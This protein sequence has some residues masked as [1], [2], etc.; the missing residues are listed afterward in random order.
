MKVPDIYISGFFTDD[1][2]NEISAI[3]AEINKRGITLG[4]RNLTG[5]MFH[6]ALDFA[7]LEILALSYEFAVAIIHS[8]CYDFLKSLILKLWNISQK[9]NLEKIP[10]TIEIDG[11]PYY[12]SSE[13]IKCKVYGK[14]SKKQKDAIID[15]TFNLAKQVENHQHELLARTPYYNAFNAHVFKYDSETD[16][17]TEID[18]NEEVRKKTIE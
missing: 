8:G 18:L 3:E 15:N 9:D 4:K 14:L 5:S 7:D 13:N 10:F 17:F 12:K 2:I 1:D 16:T 11:I 6:S